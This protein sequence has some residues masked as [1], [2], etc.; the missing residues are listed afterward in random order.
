MKNIR[1]Y[2]DPETDLPHIFKHN[3]CE[4]EVKDVIL[5]SGEDR[6]GK[7]G[8]RIAIGQTRGGRYLRVV[9]VHDADTNSIFVITAFELAGKPLAA[10]KRRRRK[11]R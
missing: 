6:A 3:V 1:Y 5:G 7:D 2:I 8:V 11:A 10:Y 4:E 9:Y